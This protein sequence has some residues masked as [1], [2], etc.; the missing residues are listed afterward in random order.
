MKQIKMV[1]GI[2]A[3]FLR[4]SIICLKLV[5]IDILDPYSFVLAGATKSRF[6]FEGSKFLNL[7]L[8]GSWT[9]QTWGVHVFTTFQRGP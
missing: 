9:H 3:I 5:K 6:G 1:E 2:W 8:D 4:A 7:I